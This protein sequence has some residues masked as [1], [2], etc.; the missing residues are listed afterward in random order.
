MAPVLTPVDS[1]AIAA[2]GYDGTLY[3]EFR[4]SGHTYAYPGVSAATYSAL[5]QAR[6]IGAYF[7]QT[8][9][10]QYAEWRVD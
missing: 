5:R 8:I 6:S 3:V 7:N 4:D 1:S 10:D 9:K 2:I